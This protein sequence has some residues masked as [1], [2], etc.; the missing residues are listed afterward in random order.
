MTGLA[1]RC[2]LAL[3]VT[4][5]LTGCASGEMSSYRFERDA[6]SLTSLASDGALLADQAAKGR[7]PSPFVA[8]HA[9]EVGAEV[10]DLA[11]VVR[12]THG[13]DEVSAGKVTRLAQLADRAS[14]LLETL[15]HAPNDQ[16]LARRTRAALSDIADQ[17]E[18][19]GESA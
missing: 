11:S 19:L 8:V 18:M 14:G 4:L 7:A 2:V 12:S 10:G 17:A 1:T 15:E 13:S 5:V 16:A 6:A 3:V 9:S